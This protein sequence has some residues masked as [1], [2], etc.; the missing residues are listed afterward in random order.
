MSRL[1]N[2]MRHPRLPTLHREPRRIESAAIRPCPSRFAPN[3]PSGSQ[4]TSGSQ[5]FACLGRLE[6]SQADPS[7]PAAATAVGEP[8]RLLG[9]CHDLLVRFRK[10]SAKRG[11]NWG[12]RSHKG[13]NFT[14][15]TPFTC[16][17]SPCNVNRL[18]QPGLSDP[19]NQ[20][21]RLISRRVGV[22]SK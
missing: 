16:R 17:K 18:L 15:I 14:G 4:I 3:S 8:L 7:H 13:G 21:Q 2:H 5:K 1:L 12:G 22:T 10:S 19:L 6:A 20:G 9:R 11:T